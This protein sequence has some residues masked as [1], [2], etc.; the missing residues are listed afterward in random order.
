MSAPVFPGLVDL[1][2]AS[3]GGRALATNDDFFASMHNLT[4]D[5][6][7]IFEAE[8]FTER[9]KWMDGWESRRRREPGYDWCTLALG[10]PG[11]VRALDIDT[12]FF[13]GNHPPWAQVEGTFHPNDDLGE[14][15]WSEILPQSPLKPGS[16]NLF[17][18]SGGPFT[19][20][21]LN[22][23]PDGG[24]ARL[25]VYG[26]VQ[27]TWRPI[28][29]PEHTAR[30]QGGEADLAALVHGGG[31][32]AASDMFFGDATNLIRP[33]RA[34]NMGQGWESRRRRV[35]GNDWVILSLAQTGTLGLLELDTNHFKGNCPA[36][37]SLSAMMAPDARPTDLIESPNWTVVMPAQPLTPHTRHFYR[38]ELSNPGPFTHVRM[39]VFPDGGV[40]RLR[41]FGTPQ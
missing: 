24:V 40:S 6:P 34:A 28:T 11:H 23:Y 26:T 13:L 19:H 3:F 18:V 37:A 41:L 4:K 35:P 8:R 14:A 32:V 12:A 7:A 15:D 1:A 36:T 2:A 29:D 27:P 10:S 22:I 39:D 31:V 5:E 30:V 25:R 20:I 16:H 33:G 9:G 17:P 21:R 38:D